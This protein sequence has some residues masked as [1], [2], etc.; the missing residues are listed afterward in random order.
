[1]FGNRSEALKHKMIVNPITT[2]ITTIIIVIIIIIIIIM[3][4]VMKRN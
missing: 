2:T 1:M 3:P 4:G